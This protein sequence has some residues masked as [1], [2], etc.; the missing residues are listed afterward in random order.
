[1]NPTFKQVTKTRYVQQVA[2]MAHEIF[3]QHYKKLT[4]KVAAALADRYQSDVETDDQIHSGAVNY[5]LIYLGSEGGRLL[6]ARPFAGRRALPA[7][8]LSS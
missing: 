6:C 1:M 7:A 4:P 3:V 5:F 8:P 2:E